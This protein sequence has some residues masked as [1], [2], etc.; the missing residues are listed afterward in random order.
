MVARGEI[1]FLILALA[2]SDHIF[3]PKFDSGAVEEAPVLGI[4]LVVTWAI[5]LCTIVGRLC[6]GA[7]MRRVKRLGQGEVE[8]EK[9][10]ATGRKVVLDF[11]G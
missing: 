11:W 7:L 8:D 2:E 4:F 5:V 10:E 9:G 3:A 6:I 1:G